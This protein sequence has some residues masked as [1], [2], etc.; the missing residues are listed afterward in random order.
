[1]AKQTLQ[2]AAI[3]S[4]VTITEGPVGDRYRNLLE[5]IPDVVYA[6]DAMGKLAAINLPASTFYGYSPDE[7]IGRDFLAFV[8]PDDQE[9]VMASF[10]EALET[11]R[12]WTRGLRFRLIAKD[13]AIHWGEVNSHAH[14]DDAGQ[15]LGEEGALRNINEQKSA[16]AAL[17]RLHE[18]LEARVASRTAALAAKN[19]ALEK[20][21]RRHAATVAQLTENR[22]A[23]AE[24]EA[25]YRGILDTVKTGLLIID[26][27]T[28]RVVDANPAA[29][30]LLASSREAL[31]GVPCRDLVC[32]GNNQGCPI[33]DAGREIDHTET[34]V[35]ARDG[36]RLPV[37][38]T[39]CALDIGGKRYLVESLTDI[40]EQKRMEA[41]LRHA[42]KM[43][44]IGTLAGG[45][46]H[47]FNNILAAIIG[48]TELA[49][50]DLPDHSDIHYHLDEV[51][52]A[53]LRAKDLVSQIL[54]FSRR[55]PSDTQPLDL[56]LIVKEGL[57]LIRAMLPATVTIDTRIDEEIHQVVADGG[58]MHQ[59]VMNLCKNAAQAMGDVGGTISVV[60]ENVTLDADTV[61]KKPHL[62]AG[63]HVR[64]AVSD[65]GCGMS[66]EV[67]RTIFDPYYTTK[68]VDQGTGLGLTVVYGI[69]ETH[70]GDISVESAPGCGSTFSVIL[71]V[72][73]E[74]VPPS[75]KPSP[76][77]PG[78]QGHILFVDDEF[79]IARLGRWELTRMGYTVDAE[80]TP[81]GALARFR[82]DPGRYDLV[83]TDVTMPGMTGDELAGHIRRLRPD[84]PVILCTGYRNMVTDAQ[85][86]AAGFDA[87]L[88]KPY[89]RRELA[90]VVHRVFRGRAL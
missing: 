17:Q 43:E 19:R 61:R 49:A 5:N 75:D 16:E 60:L 70:G 46:A 72:S 34:E 21:I 41:T 9:A 71:P 12:E 1:M 24:R 79:A 90:A 7:I 73:R 22:R 54:S 4:Q 20:E 18:E 27:D 35:V 50:E 33:I 88:N 82:A 38:K 42:Q 53:S 8:Y 63:D 44:A 15:Y 3:D 76:E 84:I 80:T 26:A 40:S 68:D 85:V 2:E 51:L 45:I 28:R 55:R 74:A 10:L 52:T 62:R 47:D 25:W 36:R 78:G 23:L 6:L 30:N 31:I 86:Q 83:I 39:V 11:R 89:L 67:V 81:A 32:M 13:G 56:S 14:F 37:Y 48:F 69:V 58:Q 65:T 29:A 59:I 66:P 77:V 64:L 87:M 57:R